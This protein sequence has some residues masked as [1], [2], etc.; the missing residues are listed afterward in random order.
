MLSAF[1]ATGDL[2]DTTDL[3][4]LLAKKRHGVRR[5][6]RVQHRAL[7][8]IVKLQSHHEAVR[9]LLTNYSR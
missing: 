6:R 4:A 8:Q 1:F 3:D 5:G 9:N 7:R 2:I